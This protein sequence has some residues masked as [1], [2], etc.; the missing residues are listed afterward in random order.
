MFSFLLGGYLQ[1]ELLGHMV[2]L[3]LFLLSEVNIGILTVS[4]GAGARVQ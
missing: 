1:V 4:A 2:T 3:T